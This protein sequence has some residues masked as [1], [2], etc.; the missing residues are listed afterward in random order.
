MPQQSTFKD[1][2]VVFKKHPVTDDLVTVKDK[3]AIAQSISNLLQTNNG[4]RPFKPDIGSGIRELLFEQADWGTA[5][6]ISGRV[7]EC[8]VKYEPRINVLTVK[9]D[10]D[11]DNNG[12]DVSIEYEILGRDDGRIVADV[13]LERT[14]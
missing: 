12:F 7:R 10:P 11:F 3:V 14:R 1:L 4:D 6:A 9:A 5:A 13:F 2:S 8:L